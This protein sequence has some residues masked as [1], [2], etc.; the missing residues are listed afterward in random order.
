MDICTNWMAALVDWNLQEIFP[1]VIKNITIEKSAHL[2]NDLK[3]TLRIRRMISKV[4]FFW[5]WIQNQINTSLQQLNVHGVTHNF[6]TK[7]DTF[8]LTLSTNHLFNGDGSKQWQ[9]ISWNSICF[10]VST[11]E[12]YIHDEVDGED[13]LLNTKWKCLP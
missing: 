1:H 5:G 4:I 12:D 13:Y 11:Q 6:Y 2:F 9:K 7:L 8:L 10:F 3:N